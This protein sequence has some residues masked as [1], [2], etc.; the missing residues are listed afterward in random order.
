MMPLLGFGVSSVF[1]GFAIYFPELFLTRLEHGDRLLP[2]CRS[3]HHGL[4]P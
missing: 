2:K 1:G 4:G 3:L